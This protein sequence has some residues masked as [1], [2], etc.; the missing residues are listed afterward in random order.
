V[1]GLAEFD[2]DVIGDVHRIVDRL[3]SAQEEFPLQPK[4]G[5]SDFDPFDQTAHVAGAT[6]KVVDGRFDFILDGA[7]FTFRKVDFGA[8]ERLL[9]GGGKFSGN[10]KSAE[11]V[12]E[13][14]GQREFQDGIPEKG[15]EVFPRGPVGGKLENTGVIIP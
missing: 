12:A 9:Q 14:G 7:L 11:A 4:W 2:H 13:I 5:G 15:S 1:K 8:V 10:A 3:Q 6:L